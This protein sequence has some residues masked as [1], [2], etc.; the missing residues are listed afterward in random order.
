MST[1]S[2]EKCYRCTPII[3]IFK[4][5]F[6]LFKKTTEKVE[7][8]LVNYYFCTTIETQAKKRYLLETQQL[9][10]TSLNQI[11]LSVILSRNNCC[12]L[13][14]MVLCA[15]TACKTFQGKMVFCLG[16]QLAFLN[17]QQNFFEDFSFIIFTKVSPHS[18][19]F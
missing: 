16:T 5:A 8:V 2:K 7:Q 1:K 19:L 15:K 18:L 11:C 10:G 14:Q 17:C 4:S 9:Q 3:V 13:L 6:W 12:K